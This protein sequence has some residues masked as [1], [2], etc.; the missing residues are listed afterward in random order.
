MDN[1]KFNKKKHALMGPRGG[2]FFLVKDKQTGQYKK[3][4][5]QKKKSKLVPSPPASPPKDPSLL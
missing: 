5:N 2:E 3:V 1:K 4:Y